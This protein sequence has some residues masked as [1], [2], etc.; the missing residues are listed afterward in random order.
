MFLLI[1]F[2]SFLFTFINNY[3]LRINNLHNYTFKMAKH[4]KKSTDDRLDEI[5][6]MLNGVQNQHAEDFQK[7][8]KRLITLEK[9][10]D[11]INE[12]FEDHRKISD[13]LTKQHSRLESE[14]KELKQKTEELDSNVNS[15][16][17]EV[18]DLEQYSRRDC[19]EVSGVPLQRDEDAEQSIINIG[20]VIGID[21]DREDIQACHRINSKP[22]AAIICKFVNRKLKE[23]FMKN[24]REITRMESI[25][26]K[27]G[28][29]SESNS[30]G[31]LK[32]FLNE[33]L[34]RRNKYLFKLVRDRKKEK[35][36]NFAWT[37]NGTIFARKSKE[38]E[39]VKIRSEVDIKKIM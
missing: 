22:N 10:M 6:K 11:F 3:D 30:G 5:I 25:S 17:I 20:K 21:V 31:S 39:A 33:S 23:A 12:K 19:I 13:N 38:T 7:L 28:F 27:L 14:N 8:E 35:D 26:E 4:L 2:L 32:L 29:S 37:K 24:K 9:S 34:T 1:S 16:S 36:W 15:L 18:D